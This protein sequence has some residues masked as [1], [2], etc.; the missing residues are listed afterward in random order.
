MPDDPGII[1]KSAI[2]QSV[3]TEAGGF[4]TTITT[5]ASTFLGA[6][7]LFIDKLLLTGT[8]VTVIVLAISWVSLVTSIACIARVRFLN[9]K[10]GQLAL[11]ESYDAAGAI[12]TQSWKYST[13]A[14]WSLILGM[15][16]LVVVGLMNVNNLIKKE[17]TAMTNPNNTT[18]RPMEKTIP[19]GSLKP[20][21]TPVQTPAQTPVST[22]PINQPSK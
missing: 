13:S 3:S 6:S 12:D 14:Q 1:P 2:L 10:S 18:P 4:Y 15:A 8:I 17:N 19:Y 5:I 11:M 9:L 16:A 20:G 22:P 7:L 21:T